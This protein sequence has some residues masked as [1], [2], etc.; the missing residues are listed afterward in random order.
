[1]K[2]ADAIFFPGRLKL[3]L[4]ERQYS[5]DLQRR[6]AETTAATRSFEQAAAMAKCWADLTLSSRHLGR[7]IEGLG[8]E[9]AEQRDAFVD[10][11]VHHRREAAEGPDPEHEL[12]A[13][14]V[15]GGRVQMRDDTPGQG[16]GVHHRR[17]Q[18]DKVARL[19]TMT[20]QTYDVDPC[21]EPPACFLDSRKL[22]QLLDAEKEPENPAVSVASADQSER[23][24]WQPEPLARSC[25]ATMKCIADF[26]WM[27]LAEAKRRHFFT[28]ERRAF[29]GDGQAC[30]WTLH[31]GQF[32]DFVPILDFL[33]LASYLY[34]AAKV[35]EAATVTERYQRW[36]REAWQGRSGEVLVELQQAMAEAGI[37]EG[38][39]PDEHPWRPLQ[40]AATYLNNHQDKMNYPEYRRQGL[41]TTSSLIESQIKEFNARVKGSEKFWNQQNAEAL[42]QI[43]AWGLRDDGPT[44]R[45]QLA[46]RPGCVFRRRSNQSNARCSIA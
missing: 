33:H 25:V 14:F 38:K 32:A 45:K 40:K 8:T 6:L 21:P 28:A 35:G 16:P 2:P 24:R 31:A 7:I 4:D 9:L 34:G 29:V 10:D 44:L 26:R 39:L 3:R 22:E 11:I 12:A 20:T 23:Q 43:I 27:V 30:N 18:E 41:P 15:D 37:G 19:Q 42:L 46:N 17:W 5:P 13:V 1:V 36:V